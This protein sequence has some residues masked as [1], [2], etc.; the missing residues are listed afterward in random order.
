MKLICRCGSE[1]PHI[2]ALLDHYEVHGGVP[3][4]RFFEERTTPKNDT[5]SALSV[6]N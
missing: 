6:G 3:Q 2:Q 5:V 1:V 4:A